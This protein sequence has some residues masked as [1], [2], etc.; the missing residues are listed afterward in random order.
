MFINKERRKEKKKRLRISNKCELLLNK[1]MAQI[2]AKGL[3]GDKVEVDLTSIFSE[4]KSRNIPIMEED[5]ADA[6]EA[7][8]AQDIMIGTSNRMSTVVDAKTLRKALPSIQMMNAISRI[9]EK[10]TEG[11]Y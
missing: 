5:L 11:K 4:F 7:G 8:F 10:K 3:S 9:N 2:D 6:I 1:V